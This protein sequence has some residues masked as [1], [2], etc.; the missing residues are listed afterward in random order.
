M[1]I[2]KKILVESRDFNKFRRTFGEGANLI[3]GIDD[4]RE[5]CFGE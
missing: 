3:L 2:S 5:H 4:V 1:R